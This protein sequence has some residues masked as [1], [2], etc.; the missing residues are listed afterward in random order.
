MF[1]RSYVVVASTLLLVSACGG[2][3]D[4][5]ARPTKTA[6]ASATPRS[7]V[8]VTDAV[9][10]KNK[11]GSATLSARITNHTDVT[12]ELAEVDFGADRDYEKFGPS[13]FFGPMTHT[14]LKPGATASTGSLG[15][16]T[17]FR[18][19]KSP[20]PGAT[21][22]LQFRFDEI[23]SGEI[24]PPTVSLDVS[25]VARTAAYDQVAGNGSITNIH[26]VD[27]KIVV[28]PGQAKA[29]VGGSTTGTVSDVAYEM[30]T[31]VDATGKPVKYRHQTATGGPYGLAVLAGKR[32]FFGGPPYRTQEGDFEGD[33][34]YFDAK[35]VKVGE[36]I[37]VTVPF[38]SGDV[39]AV[40]NVVAG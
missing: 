22:P 36:K 29:Y 18:I 14:P 1:V 27:A 26:L 4:P 32:T 28:V 33:A 30:P 9:L 37:T 39:K 38:Q 25:V 35:D 15:D 3:A 31:A 23:D 16:P 6:S 13:R 40:F 7:D 34:D 2:S 21:I 11:D 8:E 19:I 17:R 5:V 10:V 20:K 24:D 12:R